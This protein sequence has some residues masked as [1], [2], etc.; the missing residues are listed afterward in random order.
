MPTSH[1]PYRRDLAPVHKQ[2][3]GLPASRLGADWA[4]ITRF[5]QPTPTTAVRELTTF[6][7]TGDGGYRRDHERHETVLVDTAVLPGMLREHGVDARVATT[8][9]AAELPPG[10]V[11]VIGTGR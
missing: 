11:A 10:L 9:G 5:V 4:L 1:A 8:F 6:V 3:F 2:A 7:R